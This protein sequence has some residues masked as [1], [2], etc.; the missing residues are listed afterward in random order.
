MYVPKPLNNGQQNKFYGNGNGEG[1]FVAFSIF[2]DFQSDM[3]NLTMEGKKFVASARIR[4][5]ISR[6]FAVWS[7]DM[8]KERNY[9]EQGRTGSFDLHLPTRSRVS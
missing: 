5:Q 9:D 8:V 7:T 3:C 6:Q 2:Y 1:S 4:M